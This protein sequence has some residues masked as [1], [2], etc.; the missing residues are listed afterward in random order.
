[1]EYNKNRTKRYIYINC[2]DELFMSKLPKMESSKLK[3]IY[4]CCIGPI[5]IKKTIRIHSNINI[6]K[7]TKDTG[8]NK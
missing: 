4:F 5:K 7:K 8:I 3:S 6:Y 2:V 1:M